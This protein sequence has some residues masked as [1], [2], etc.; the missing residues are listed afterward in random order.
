MMKKYFYILTILSVSLAL[1]FANYSCKPEPEPVTPPVPSKPT[2]F[3]KK[4]VVEEGT[5]TW[6]GWCPRGAIGMNAMR[7]KYPN[8]FIGIAVHG[9]DTMQVANYINGLNFSGF[10]QAAI[11]RKTT[12]DPEAK[13]LDA[14]ITKADTVSL[15]GI[16]FVS[17]QLNAANTQIDVTV[18]VTSGVDTVV[19][20]RIA[21]VIIE[22]D[23]TGTTSAY[24]QAN[25]YSGGGYGVMGGYENLPSP[26]PASQM[27][28][29]EVARGIYP[30]F[31]GV[32]GSVP[33]S[34]T[35]N[36]PV[37]YSYTITL[38]S[39][40]NNL[41]KIELIALL[42]ENKAGGFKPWQIINATKTHLF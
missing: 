21:L 37:T 14:I 42:L 4:T 40:I 1:I 8:K 28:Y 24:D 32:D 6:C 5:G 41:A 35:A 25:N 9:R 18:Q 19:N 3:P 27:V 12:S 23:V 11:D 10:P 38:P 16:E 20:Q 7:A 17:A 31:N 33:E 22:N 29:Q 26:V 13:T 36:T 39:N 34:L 15:F 30:S 2:L